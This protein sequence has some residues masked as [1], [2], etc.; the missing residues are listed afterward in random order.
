MSTDSAAISSWSGSSHRSSRP[1]TLPGCTTATR[2]ATSPSSSVAWR[3][4]P[5]GTGAT[6][7]SPARTA[8]RIGEGGAGAG[9]S[10][11]ARH[12]PDATV[13][14]P[15]NRAPRSSAPPARDRMPRQGVPRVQPRIRHAGHAGRDPLEPGPAGGERQGEGPPLAAVQEGGRQAGRTGDEADEHQYEQVGG[16]GQRGPPRKRGHHPVETDAMG[17]GRSREAVPEG[18]QRGVRRRATTTPAPRRGGAKAANGSSGP[19]CGEKTSH[20][21]QDRSPPRKPNPLA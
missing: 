19:P 8:R 7:S 4:Y 1:S 17:D 14:N 16:D 10:T 18:S 12:A 2:A 15:V 5:A 13:Q 21:P 6:I 9:V 3:R 11:Q 20:P